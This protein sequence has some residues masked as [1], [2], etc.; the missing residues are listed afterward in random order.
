MGK[1]EVGRGTA[2]DQRA[3]ALCLPQDDGEICLHERRGMLG[4]L[5]EGGL[6]LLGRWDGCGLDRK[7][8]CG[9]EGA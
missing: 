7:G 5:A 8:C 1:V 6:V 4:C 9:L 2:G 3:Q